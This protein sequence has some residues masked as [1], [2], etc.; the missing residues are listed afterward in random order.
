MNSSQEDA[1]R[2]EH[3]QFAVEPGGTACD[4]RA[5]DFR[6]LGRFDG[7]VREFLDLLDPDEEFTVS[8]LPPFTGTFAAKGA[9]DVVCSALEEER[10]DRQVRL[11]VGSA[12]V[13]DELRGRMNQQPRES[14]DFEFGP[15]SVRLLLGDI[16]EVEADAIVNAS[17][18]RMQLGAGVAGAIRRKAGPTLQE[19]M[20]AKAEVRDIKPGDVLVTGSHGLSHTSRILHAATVAGTQDV[21]ARAVARCLEL[22][23]EKKIR[24]LAFP[25]LGTGVGGMDMRLCAEVFVEELLRYVGAT[26]EPVLERVTLV[27]WTADDFDVFA[28]TFEDEVERSDLP[29]SSG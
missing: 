22:T 1:P 20:S 28:E 8:L 27:L 7:E 18:I 11:L 21:L 23:D 17:N 4:L 26:P 15:L 19:E 25:A 12:R 13:A 6:T 9:F 24:S 29:V 2:S 10:S 14:R 3:I 5:G 16:T